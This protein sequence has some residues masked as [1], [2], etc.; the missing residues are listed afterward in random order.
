MKKL[1]LT[2]AAL[3]IC[4]PLY[5]SSFEASFRDNAV[6]VVYTSPAVAASTAAIIVDLSD[7]TNWPHK[8]TSGINVSGLWVDVD[9]AGASTDTVKVGVVTNIDA[10]SGTV[11]W[12]FVAANTANR[13]STPGLQS[14][15]IEGIVRTKVNSSNVTPYILTNNSSSQSTIFQTDV[16]LPTANGTFVAP[17]VGDIVAFIEGGGAAATATATIH[18]IYSAER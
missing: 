12:F 2:L 15:I 4:S 8:N 17:A 10:S 16:L 6:E 18:L 5:A 13:V 1:I 7:T 11:K 14:P 9:K 3:V